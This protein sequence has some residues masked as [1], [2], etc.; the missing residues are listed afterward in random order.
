MSGNA[1][2]SHRFVVH[3]G[4]AFL[5]T[6]AAPMAEFASNAKNPLDALAALRDAASAGRLELF[7]QDGNGAFKPY[8]QEMADT[9]D[10]FDRSVTF[11]KAF[12]K[13][14]V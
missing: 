8:R 2:P 4:A 3:L 9:G 14:R 10:P 1:G 13:G 11:E 6:A 7:A 5:L 12:D